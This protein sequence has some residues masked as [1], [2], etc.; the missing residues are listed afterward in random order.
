MAIVFGGLIVVKFG[1]VSILIIPLVILAIFTAIKIIQDPFWGFLLIIFFLPFERVPSYNFA[2]MDLKINILLGFFTLFFWLAALL[3]NPQKYK[4]TP[5]AL[6]IPMSVFVL[7][8]VL[9]LTQAGNLG[10]GLQVL[11][12][13]IFTVIL[14]ILSLNMV[15]DKESLKKIVLVLFSSSLI[16][17]VFGILQ[18]ALDILGFP[19][20]ITLLKEGYDSAVF[21]FPRIQAFSMEPLYLANYL[22]MPILLFFAYFFAKNK[23]KENENGSKF[24]QILEKLFS[25][26]W[27][28]L[29]GLALL[30]VVFVLTVSRGGYVALAAGLG[31][32]M[33][34]YAKKVFTWRNLIIVAILALVG[35][36]AIFAISQGQSRALDE[37]IGHILI[38]DFATGDSIQGRL[39]LTLVALQA[40][41]WHRILGVGIGN[42]G[43]YYAFY[44]AVMP[45]EGWA[46]VNN[47]YIETLAETGI[48]GFSAFLVLILTILVRSVKAFLHATDS[49]LK[50][51][52]LGLLAAFVGVLV[53]YTTFS[54]LYIIHIWVLIGL[55]IGVQ[56]IIF[57]NTKDEKYEST[58]K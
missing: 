21:G 25:N 38:K 31:V 35:L 40:F 36:V 34:F 15:K 27:F 9:S 58:K 44:P 55:L 32:F 22:L 48:I 53:Q 19:R 13:T 24:F 1:F 47:Q 3:L 16:V 49:F 50:A 5:N 30:L 6:A 39:H 33:I 4:L 2:G 51:T 12:F 54:T 7:S 10:R 20:S 17:G 26:S 45:K 46:I 42:Y 14:S 23:F 56:N 41:D 29:A 28:I 18:F 52:I 43:P 57:K 37:F 11:A 8:L